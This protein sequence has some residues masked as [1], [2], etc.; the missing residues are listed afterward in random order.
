MLLHLT[1]AILMP[2]QVIPDDHPHTLRVEGR[3]RTYLVH[4]PPNHDPNKRAPVVLA[5][6]G[7]GSNAD[8]TRSGEFCS[9]CYQ[10]GWF[11]EPN[12]SVDDMMA[13]VEAKLRELHFSLDLA[14]KF[15]REIPRL[16]RWGSA[17]AGNSG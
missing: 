13:Q 3:T 5:Y 10:Q 8:G 14:R 9:H 4:V 12:I 1:L 16:S 11:T 15:V 7:G 6:H 17:P 2:S